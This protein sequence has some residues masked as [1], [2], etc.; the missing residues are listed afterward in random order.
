MP[1][2]AADARAGALRRPAA[3][4]P[5]GIP[6]LLHQGDVL[7]R[8]FASDPTEL[9]VDEVLNSVRLGCGG[10]LLAARW[11]LAHGG[12]AMN[13]HGGFHHAAKSHGSGLCVFNDLAVTL[14]VL[15]DEG[16]PVK[17]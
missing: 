6:R 7:A 11:V 9:P 16:F 10:T 1:L 14:A 3:R 2:R 15:R 12:A 5:G 8:I 17:W 13:L 4:S